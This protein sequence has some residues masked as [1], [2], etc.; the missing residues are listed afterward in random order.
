MRFALHTH[1][2]Q[3]R[4]LITANRGYG[5][6]QVRLPLNKRD[7]RAMNAVILASLLGIKLAGKT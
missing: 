1:K 5:H 4:L 7:E 6:V 2:L 3:L